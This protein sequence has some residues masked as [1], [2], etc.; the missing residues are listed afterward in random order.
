ML[1]QGFIE[2]GGRPGI[3]PP[4]HPQQKFPLPQNFGKNISYHL[5]MFL[6]K[7]YTLWFQQYDASCQK[8]CQNAS[9]N[10]YF[11]KVSWGACPKTPLVGL[12]YPHHLF[13]PPPQHKFLYESLCRIHDR[14]ISVL[15][16]CAVLQCP[17]RPAPVL[18]LAANIIPA[19]TNQLDALVDAYKCMGGW[20]CVCVCMQGFI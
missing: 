11:S 3:S 6:F 4:P 8:P 9:K 18:K 15:G 10:A 13:P 20:V 1:Q 2:R 19:I 5:L 12:C 17:L 16:L 7:L 14:K